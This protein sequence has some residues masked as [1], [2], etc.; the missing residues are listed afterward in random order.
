MALTRSAFSLIEL[1]VTIGIITLLLGLL[2]PVLG[3]ARDTARGAT[4]MATLKQINTGWNATTLTDRRFPNTVSPGGDK[5][6][7]VRILQTL[8]L[9]VD[10]KPVLACPSV[11]D[12]YGEYR[13]GGLT[14][15]GVNTRW[16]PGEAPGDNEGKLLSRITAPAEYPLFS[17]TAAYRASKPAQVY[18]E[19][20]VQPGA[21]DG[22][23]RLDDWKIGFFHE[24]DTA[25]V[26]YADL[27]VIAETRAVF[28]GSPDANGV[29]MY[30]F[31]PAPVPGGL[32]A[33]W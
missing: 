7:D 23:T 19:I 32:A 12:A 2:L 14:T 1:L 4:C 27:S 3:N 9:P 18:D 25:N 6:W 21:D 33:A 28:D 11:E 22:V 8:E 16:T 24:G 31:N 13:T 29:P 20:G 10:Q 17:D 15:Y 26:S 5:R 30:F